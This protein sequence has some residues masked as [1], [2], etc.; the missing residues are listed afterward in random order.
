MAVPGAAA[1]ANRVAMAAVLVIAAGVP[2]LRW[3]GARNYVLIKLVAAQVAVLLVFAV[4]SLQRVF[5]AS[6][7]LRGLRRAAGRCPLFHLAAAGALVLT[8]VWAIVPGYRSAG[9]GELVR[10][11]TGLGVYAVTVGVL[12]E[13]RRRG[14][15]LAAWGI[16]TVV[17]CLVGQWQV[18]AKFLHSIGAVGLPQQ[19]APG[20]FDV[21]LAQARY[22]I[23]GTFGNPNFFGAY[24]VLMIPAA[25][26]LA[27]WA[28]GRSRRGLAVAGAAAVVLMLATA[29][30]TGS[31]GTQLGLAV[32]AVA[33]AVFANL[34]RRLVLLVLGLLV[35]IV[36]LVSYEKL[37]DAV[38]D[39]RVYF[40][41]GAR[42]MAAERRLLGWGPGTFFIHYPLFKA[43]EFYRFGRPFEVTMH[44]HCEPLEIAAETGL[45]GLALVAV[46]V[47]AFYRCGVRQLLRQC[48]PALRSLTAAVMAGITGLLATSLVGVHL[49]F[50]G[51]F[52]MLWFAM[53]V[54]MSAEGM[55]AHAGAS[56]HSCADAPGEGLRRRSM[57][58]LASAALVCALAAAAVRF[59]VLPPIW[60]S[61]QM[62]AGRA[63]YEAGRME[64]AAERCRG[65]LES[66][67][68]D[69][70]AHYEL[71]TAYA[72]MKQWDEARASYE[73]AARLAPWF[74]QLHYNLGVV[75]QETGQTRK[76]VEEY[77]AEI[78]VNPYNGDAMNNL[79]LLY[80]RLGHLRDAL[81]LF[82]HAAYL[83]PE[84]AG[85]RDNLAAAHAFL[86]NYDEAEKILLGLLQEQPER[87]E[88]LRARLEALRSS[89]AND[90]RLQQ[91]DDPGVRRESP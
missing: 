44:A 53:G 71:A 61:V 20:A 31:Q 69:V 75:Y 40:W 33:L 25:V 81:E 28:V 38:P 80:S 91:E 84:V 57:L 35:V 37:I 77:V 36:L 52:L 19:P 3:H 41:K 60:G 46:L 27:V 86:G 72:Q 45:L 79:G 26:M 56:A 5:C 88:E 11:A 17:S 29:V 65:A 10:L 62:R 55:E 42:A 34:R 51:T 76:A 22:W 24:L 82:E 13:P 1:V 78:G 21:H 89:R 90:G 59:V 70:V 85:Y 2:L 16:A 83:Y 4:W 23:E 48:S 68:G 8:V 73:S 9:T 18:L 30:M 64:A 12:S 74:A 49:R 39:M 54:V 47:V 87:E 63:R 50:P 15:V 43:T 67:R 66:Q 7:G 6:P 14:A 32:A 58:R